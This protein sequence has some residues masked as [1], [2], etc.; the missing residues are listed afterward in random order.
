MIYSKEG[1]VLKIK[2][3][4]PLFKTSYNYKFENKE[5]QDE[6]GLNMYDFDARG[7]MPDLGRTTTHDPLAEKFYHLSPQSFL[8]NNPLRF[9]DPTGMESDDW[10]KKG[11]DI[12]YDSAVTSQKEATEKYGTE[13]THLNE[14]TTLTGTKDGQ[15][16]YQYTF[17]DNGT[18]TDKDG[19]TLSTTENITTE[20]GTTIIGSERKSGFKVSYGFNGALG[21]GW[22]FDV[23]FVKDS[24]GNVGFF[25]SSNSNVGLG[26]DGGLS[27]G[28][29]KSQHSGPFLLEDAG[30]QSL[31][32]SV[33]VET[34]V[35]GIGL[36]YGGTFSSSLSPSQRLNISN[37]GTSDTGRGNVEGSRSLVQ[38]PSSKVSVGAMYRKSNVSVWQVK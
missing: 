9:T 1:S 26:V 7:Y 10:I 36:N 22:G 21:G 4:P 32:A 29:I 34:P 8:N 15:T 35:G 16:S 11:K 23:G 30:G 13:A 27:F 20:A 2:P 24:G 5:W 31:S 28:S 18:V 6:L 3:K 14:G 38:S 37:Y 17:H 19:G 12:F 25:L 33:G